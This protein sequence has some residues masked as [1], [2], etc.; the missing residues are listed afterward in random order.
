MVDSGRQPIRSQKAADLLLL[1][2]QPGRTMRRREG[3]GEVQ[4]EAHVDVVFARKTGSP[5]RILHEY[6]SAGG[7]HRTAKNAVE[8]AV[9]CLD[10]ASPIVSVHDD[11]CTGTPH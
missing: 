7:R 3:R 9:G 8:D 2:H 6:H 11:R 10:I 1:F 4:V 5:L